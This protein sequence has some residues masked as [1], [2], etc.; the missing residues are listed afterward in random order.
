VTQIKR[1]PD[2]A[3]SHII[4]G[5]ALTLSQPSLSRRSTLRRGVSVPATSGG[6]IISPTNVLAVERDRVV[7]LAIVGGLAVGVV[8]AFAPEALAVLA[9][10]YPI[11]LALVAVTGGSIDGRRTRGRL[12]V[13]AFDFVAGTC[14]AWLQEH[15]SMA[16]VIV[17]AVAAGIVT[18]VL[19]VPAISA[20]PADAAPRS[21]RP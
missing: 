17:W 5:R 20:A 3:Q 19:L 16:T 1:L 21:P 10:A 13:A 2:P 11:G 14:G 15:T 9:L 12:A 7:R 18:G 6:A 4:V 8:G